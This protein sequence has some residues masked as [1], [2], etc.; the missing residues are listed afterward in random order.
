MIAINDNILG[1]ALASDPYIYNGQIL[2][3]SIACTGSE[4]SAQFCNLD[5]NVSTECVNTARAAKIRCYY[6][7]KLC[8][9]FPHFYDKK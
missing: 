5:F 8:I 7:S 1:G 3:E 4:V 2:F 6:P 9:N